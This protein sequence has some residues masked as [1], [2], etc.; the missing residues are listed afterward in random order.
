M[1][2][3]NGVAAPSLGDLTW[4]KSRYSGAQG[5]CVELARLT[6]GT[7]ALRNSRDPGGAALLFTPA[8]ITAMFAGVRDGEFDHLVD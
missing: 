4:V 7:V 5:N 8:E 1:K 6:D 3:K 2:I